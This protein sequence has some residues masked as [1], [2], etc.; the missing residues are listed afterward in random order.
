M[1]LNTDNNKKLSDLLKK[2]F[3]SL[4]YWNEYKSKMQTVTTG[5][6]TENIDTKRILLDS[7]FQGVN[8]LFV[9]GFDVRNNLGIQ[10]N[11]YRKYFF[12]KDRN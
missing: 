5:N 10:R 12:T 1:T 4:V 7:S 3:K 2:V 9:T 8:R 6:A 11:S